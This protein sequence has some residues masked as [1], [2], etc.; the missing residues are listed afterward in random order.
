MTKERLFVVMM[1]VSGEHENYD[2]RIADFIYQPVL[3]CN[4]GQVNT[5]L[6]RISNLIKH[7][8]IFLAYPKPTL[9]VVVQ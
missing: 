8:R 7:S 4:T 2:F 5:R 6:W 9:Q 3:L 1:P